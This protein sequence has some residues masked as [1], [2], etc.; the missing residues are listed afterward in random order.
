[1]HPFWVSFL[2]GLHQCNHYH[3]Q[4]TECFHHHK[5]FLLAPLQS[6]SPTP[7]NHWFILCPCKS[8]L[9]FLVLCKSPTLRTLCLASSLSKK[10]VR[11][12]CVVACSSSSL[13]RWMLC[14]CMVILQFVY[15]LTHW[16]TFGCI[17]F[18]AIVNKTAMGIH[19]EV[20]VLISLGNFWNG[21]AV[22]YCKYIFNLMFN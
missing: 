17:Q 2:K 22:L 11:F 13:S 15:L 12:I 20:C 4:D 7:G 8:A 6:E 9:S 1:M 21:I 14:H 16:W 19:V 10:S 3:N 5:N 18:G